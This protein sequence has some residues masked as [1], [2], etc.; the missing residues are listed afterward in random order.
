MIDY[1]KHWTHSHNPLSFQHLKFL[2][3]SPFIPIQ[4]VSLTSFTPSKSV[5]AV[6]LYVVQIRRKQQSA[7][8][9]SRALFWGSATCY[10]VILPN[11]QINIQALEDI[12]SAIDSY[13]RATNF[14]SFISFYSLHILLCKVAA[15]LHVQVLYLA[16]FKAI[17]IE[18]FTSKTT[19]VEMSS[20]WDLCPNAAACDPLSPQSFRP[21]ATR[22]Q[23][24][25][26]HSGSCCQCSWVLGS[27]L[28]ISLRHRI[29]HT[30][31]TQYN[32]F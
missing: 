23:A 32:T 26:F 5:T 13:K 9:V 20:P 8:G 6:W 21:W 15:N 30:N 4:P 17:S 14:N 25:L 12:V 11:L 10:G 31:T 16:Y 22:P 28:K 24:G 19:F 29:I 27:S 2:W 18:I 7:P 1:Q 3:T